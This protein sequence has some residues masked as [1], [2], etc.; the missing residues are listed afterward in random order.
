MSFAFKV[1]CCYASFPYS[2]LIFYSLFYCHSIFKVIPFGFRKITAAI[3]S[4]IP[5]FLPRPAFSFTEPLFF[6]FDEI[7]RKLF[8]LFG[9]IPGKRHCKLPV[10][11]LQLQPHKS[12]IPK[13]QASGAFPVF[14]LLHKYRIYI[15]RNSQSI[16]HTHFHLKRMDLNF[17]IRIPAFLLLISRLHPV[18][19][20]IKTD[21]ESLHFADLIQCPKTKSM[22]RNLSDPNLLPVCKSCHQSEWNH[23]NPVYFSLP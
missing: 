4:C 18:E 3:A 11:A 10:L 2:R 17:R 15:Y 7:L 6:L 8:I 20:I 13:D 14:L 19:P 21:P 5:L 16:F 12:I 23:K 22:F 9:R 1:S